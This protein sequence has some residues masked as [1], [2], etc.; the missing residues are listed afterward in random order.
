MALSRSRPP[1]DGSVNLRVL[2]VVEASF[3]GVGRHVLDLVEGLGSLGVE[4]QLA[5]SPT[6]ASAMFTRRLEDLRNL[7]AIQCHPVAMTR[8]PSP[9]QLAAVRSLRGLVTSMDID[10][11]HGHSSGGGQVA[12]LVGSLTGRPSVFTP[13]AFLT[14]QTDVPPMQALAYR[15]V[16][17]ALRR[18]TGALICVSPEELRHAR[19]QKYAPPRSVVIQNG[20]ETTRPGPP[21]E[22][23]LARFPDDPAV[24]IIGFVG[25]LDHQKRPD[26]LLA[27]FAHLVGQLADTKAHLVMVGAGRLEAELHQMGD[28]LGIADK[29]SWLGEQ[30]GASL[31][32][33]FD[34][35]AVP[36]GY[37]GF[38]YVVLEALRAGTPVVASTQVPTESFGPSPTGVTVADAERPAAFA[39]A[40]ATALD[41]QAARAEIR[42]TQE[43]FTIEAMARATVESYRSLLHRS[44]TPEPA[45]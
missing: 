28:A 20:I 24:R 25:R 15:S 29:I 7:G 27:A 30:D 14:L 45:R 17:R 1:T 41:D 18:T 38:P 35:V 44:T 36:S 11:I 39:Q 9:V 6:R 10:L 31:M 32:P 5:Y 23:L 4:N 21:D 42:R 33:S 40:L 13:N 19:A 26:L 37:E 34:V 8:A 16:E 12:R 43:P 3:A 22:R 2:H